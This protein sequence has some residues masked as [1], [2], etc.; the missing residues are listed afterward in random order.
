MRNLLMRNS[1]AKDRWNS[2]TQLHMTTADGWHTDS[3][4]SGRTPD[5]ST[6][7]SART[8]LSAQQV[9]IKTARSTAQLTITFLCST[10]SS[11]ATR[12]A[13]HP[14]R[15][16]CAVKRRDSWR[17]SRWARGKA[18]AKCNKG[19]L[20]HIELVNQAQPRVVLRAPTPLHQISDAQCKCPLES[21]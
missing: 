20:A 12:S 16:K 11:Q 18:D 9:M 7:G 2:I 1:H 13:C 19:K 4:S 14:S 15:Q 6:K 21:T 10:S 5:A 8:W 17:A 3:W